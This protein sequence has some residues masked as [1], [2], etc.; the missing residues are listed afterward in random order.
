MRTRGRKKEKK[1]TFIDIFG[2]CEQ[3]GNI[4]TDFADTEARSATRPLDMAA[5]IVTKDLENK[6]NINKL[7]IYQKYT[8]Q[9]PTHTHTL[10]R[11]T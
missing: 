3:K 8:Y 11:R 4:P 1:H 10:N 6:K 2:G 7:S 9:P 5:Y